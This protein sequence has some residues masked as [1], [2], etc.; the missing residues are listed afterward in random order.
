[1]V[2]TEAEW[3]AKGIMAG[4]V[5]DR[6]TM[7]KQIIRTLLCV[8]AVSVFAKSQSASSSKT[9]TQDRDSVSGLLIGWNPRHLDSD[10]A[11]DEEE[12]NPALTSRIEDKL[13]D[14]T[15]FTH[16]DENENADPFR[17]LWIQ[18]SG[19]DVSTRL[20]Q[21]IIVPRKDGFWRLGT[22]TDLAT[23]FA[24][25][26][27]GNYRQDFFW[28]A[29]LGQKP[30]LTAINARDIACME[31]S[32]SRE[33]TY[34]GPDYF[35][36]SEFW[37][38]TCAHYDEGHYYGVRQL[39]VDPQPEQGVDGTRL[40]AVDFS[41][42]LGPAS[43]AH[44]NR[45][46]T[47]AVD[48]QGD[49]SEPGFRG[50]PADWTLLRKE[51]YWRA[52]AKFNGSGGGICGREDVDE[53][54][55]VS[56]P[57]SLVTSARALPVPWK[58]IKAAFSDATDAVVSPN[59]RLVVVFTSSQAIVTRLQGKILRRIS[60]PIP[61]GDGDPVMLEWAEGANAVRWDKVFS[62]LPPPNPAAVPHMPTP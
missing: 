23:G 20:M 58:T 52:V 56:L 30:K 7:K 36:Y 60:S 2:N 46:S 55:H 17:T 43:L 19:V 29:P 50:D 62:E 59:G 1:M 53:V 10:S 3:D 41:T 26:S 22:N 57:H 51:G 49:C 40:R 34:V 61:L 37:E 18:V 27:Q 13:R 28:S 54:L 12:H 35:G 5:L 48:W 16:F 44:F 39:N 4:N 15:S 42:L 11:R 9:P 31:E 8:L 14:G 6:S 24:D 21:H 45:L 38:A 33:L 32:V 25:A 47:K